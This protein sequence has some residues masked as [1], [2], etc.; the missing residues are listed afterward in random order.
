MRSP[1]AA[2]TLTPTAGATLSRT[3]VALTATPARTRSPTPALE[4][5]GCKKPAGD[6]ALVDVNGW[7]LN[8]RT[9]SMLAY[10]AELYGG[11]IEIT[12]YAIT[13]GSYHDNGAASF[14]THL[15]GG[16]VDL[17]V[18]R[19]GTWTVLYDDI[20]PLVHALRLA[21]FAAWFRDF[22]ELYPGSAVHIHA[23][24]I[25]DE[26]LSQAA[27][28]QLTGAYGYFRGYSGVPQANGVPVADRHGG[29]VICQWMREMG[30]SDL[31]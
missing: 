1:T 18:M 8:R 23:V 20:E 4:P 30:Y 13:Q 29:P 14:G 22:D 17:S 27:S 19:T 26:Q 7:A 15:G 5:A 9:Y 2:A 12:G 28:E 10:A 24:A 11:E 6:Y 16:A 21:G 31:R 25:G 3:P